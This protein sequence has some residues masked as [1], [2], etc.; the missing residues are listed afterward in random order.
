MRIK[1]RERL[2][3]TITER[4]TFRSSID[5]E[6]ICPV[7]HTNMRSENDGTNSE[8]EQI[9]TGISEKIRPEMGEAN[10]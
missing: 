3:V 2:I 4:V 10:Q 6:M 1:H 5:P 8:V 7:C 9:G